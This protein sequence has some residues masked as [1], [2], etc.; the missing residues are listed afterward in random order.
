M[1]STGNTIS[2]WGLLDSLLLEGM[3]E[4]PE[5]QLFEFNIKKKKKK[6]RRNKN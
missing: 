3:S 5:E 1:L 2:D 4:D 6:S